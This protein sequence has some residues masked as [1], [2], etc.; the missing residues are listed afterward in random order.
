M[1]TGWPVDEL[2]MRAQGAAG[3][4]HGNR[5]AH[6]KGV[7]KFGRWIL[8]KEFFLLGKDVLG[9]GVYTWIHISRRFG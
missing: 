2:L 3:I 5:G 1:S 7:S 6:A 4:L 9:E 8:T